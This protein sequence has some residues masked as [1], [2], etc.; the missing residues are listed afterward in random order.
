MA[1]SLNKASFWGLE[2]THLVLEFKTAFDSSLV[3]E[4]APYIQKLLKE[5]T[6]MEFRI[7][8]RVEYVER[9]KKEEEKDPQIEMICSVFR[10]TLV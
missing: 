7:D 4:E 9:E 5:K 2:D 3:K 10:A 1:V 6:N 8:T